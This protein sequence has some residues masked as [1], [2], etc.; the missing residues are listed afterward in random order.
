MQ[1]KTQQQ[2]QKSL[3]TTQKSIEAL[4]KTVNALKTENQTLKKMTEDL[5]ERHRVAQK[6]I[7]VLQQNVTLLMSRMSPKPTSNESAQLK[8]LGTRVSKVPRGNLTTPIIVEESDIDDEPKHPIELNQS[9]PL[10]KNSLPETQNNE[11]ERSLDKL[12]NFLKQ[13]SRINPL[14]EERMNKIAILYANV[15]PKDIPCTA[16]VSQQQQQQQPTQLRSRENEPP[17]SMSAQPQSSYYGTK[18]TQE[19][20]LRKEFHTF[21]SPSVHTAAAAVSAAA[22][23]QQNPKR[24]PN[25]NFMQGKL[26][27]SYYNDDDKYFSE[28]LLSRNH[29]NICSFFS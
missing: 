8:E 18:V 16:I 17:T 21:G 27:E 20:T 15:D 10:L 26:P 23:S 14:I 19:L 1:L 28:C 22:S 7:E 24:P 13:Q 3:E 25:A 2:Q 6:S 9:A 12:L 4:T 5:S 11:R 29:L